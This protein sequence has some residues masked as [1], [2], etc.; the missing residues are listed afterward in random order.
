M[1]SPSVAN[2]YI[3]MSNGCI[4]PIGEKSTIYTISTYI[5]TIYT[6]P[7]TKNE[8]MPFYKQFSLLVLYEDMI[9]RC[10]HVRY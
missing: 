2:Y 10:C 7:E 1:P 9:Y 4:Y 5:E 3:P 8:S 6:N